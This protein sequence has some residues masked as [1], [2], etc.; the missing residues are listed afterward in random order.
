MTVNSSPGRSHNFTGLPDNTT[1]NITIIG[2]NMMSNSI[3][4]NF[5][6]ARTTAVDSKFILYI[7]FHFLSGNV[8]GRVPCMLQRV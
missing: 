1:F 2:L 5:T 3:S 8:L 7:N 4:F 6:S